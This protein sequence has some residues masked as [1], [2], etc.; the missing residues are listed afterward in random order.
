MGGIKREEYEKLRRFQETG[1]EL[2]ID[3]VTGIKDILQ[4]NIEEV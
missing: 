1:Q 4:G 3:M 2:L